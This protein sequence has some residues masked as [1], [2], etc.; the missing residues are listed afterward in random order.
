ME[1]KQSSDTTQMAPPRVRI[2][3]VD[4]HI[5]GRHTLKDV[6]STQPDFAVVAE[7]ADGKAAIEMALKIL[8]DI[9]M[10][11]MPIPNGLEATRVIKTECP[12]TK[13]LILT[14]FTDN[15]RVITIMKAGADGFLINA[16]SDYEIINTIRALSMG[17]TVLS[18]QIARILWK[19]VFE[20]YKKPVSLNKSEKLSA[21]EQEVLR[22]VAKGES[23]KDIAARLNISVRSVKAYLT[24]I[25]LK[26]DV[27][28]RTEAIAACM[29]SGVLTINDLH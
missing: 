26:L 9:V 10:I 2:L 18:A 6:L 15:E 20:S 4:N 27:S 8:P 16:A 11:F 13:V 21:R 12:N 29:Q 24:T 23:N 1:T 7:A 25:F 28:S 19:Y 3:L 22:L 14:V 17:N 5:L